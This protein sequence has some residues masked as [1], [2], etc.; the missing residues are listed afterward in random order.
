[1]KTAIPGNR[2]GTRSRM[3]SES[4]VYLSCFEYDH[5][6]RIFSHSGCGSERSADILPSNFRVI[7]YIRVSWP[8]YRR[9]CPSN[10]HHRCE[11]RRQTGTRTHHYSLSESLLRAEDAVAVLH[12]IWNEDDHEPRYSGV[13]CP[14]KRLEK[15]Y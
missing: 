6:L 13:G 3:Y 9:R 7:R 4:Y 8:Q 10:H 2:A 1:M 12:L 11:R 5:L 14:H 15:A